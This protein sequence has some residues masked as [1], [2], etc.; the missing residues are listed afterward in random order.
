MAAAAL[1]YFT[2]GRSPYRGDEAFAVRYWAAPL[3][4]ILR[5]PEGLAWKEP[6]PLGT[7]VLFGAWRAVVGDSEIA[8]RALPLLVNLLGVAGMI[9]L[10]RR[11]FRNQ[12][13]GLVSGAWWALNP[14]LIWHAQDAR[15]YAIW[16][17]LSL[18]G[19]WA[20]LRATD[21]AHGMS[22][23]TRGPRRWAWALYIVVV[24]L[25]LYI[26]FLEAFIVVAHGVYMLT[27][28]RGRLRGWLGAMLIVASLCAPLAYQGWQL[29]GSGYQGTGGSVDLS[30]LVTTFPK[31]LL[32]GDV[33]VEGAVVTAL[34]LVSLVLV[35]IFDRARLPLLLIWILVPAVLLAAAATRLSVF[36][37]RY[38]IAIT[39]ALLL[40]IAW[41]AVQAARQ[42]RL[43]FLIGA[44]SGLT[45]FG[46][47]MHY[48]ADNHKAPD[49]FSLRDYLSANARA[50]DTVIMTSLDPA[51]GYADPAFEWY[52]RGPAPVI[53]LPH[54][55]LDAEAVLRAALQ[56]SRAVWYIVSGADA[57]L[58]E[59]LLVN[60]AL[61]SD[62]GAGRSFL[63]RQFRTRNADAPDHALDLRFGALELAGYS[64][65]TDPR[66][67]DTL[68][69]LLYWR[70]T[71]DPRW[72][73]FVHVIGPPKPDGLTLWT[74]HD[75]PPLAPGRDLYPLD[76]RG[77][78]PGVYQ[79]V[80]GLYEPRTGARVP[81]T[82][83]AGVAGG[84]QVALTTFT[85]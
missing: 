4:D 8:M 17:A 55:Q 68:T 65:A 78:P 24:T 80:A 76:L 21:S 5:Q 72:T 27:L 39:P 11:L 51:S 70:G 60:G 2:L 26:F 71:P 28:R 56:R 73:T 18:L 54:P 48:A 22:P 38:L 52:Y 50:E 64:L 82:T 31:V 44:F 12:W 79:I 74:Q 83:L 46:L 47:E 6:H 9:A 77:L 10:G 69:V 61:I 13:V 62:Q 29:A 53:T 33:T 85:R 40:P 19:V 57:R 59:I 32:L 15:N 63:V 75:H 58:N 35:A 16:A 14:H 43:I 34:I 7:F 41:V 30:A 42:P 1:R 37:P 20:M 67:G 45:Y 3:T 66:L 49:W 23:D 84:D 81:V 36:W 25:A